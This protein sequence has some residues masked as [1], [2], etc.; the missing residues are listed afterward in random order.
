VLADRH[1]M[2]TFALVLRYWPGYTTETEAR[3]G[4]SHGLLG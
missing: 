2:H 3:G 1:N 4:M